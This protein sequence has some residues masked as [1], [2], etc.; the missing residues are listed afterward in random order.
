MG[1]KLNVH[2]AP[3]SGLAR[4]V[5]K[6]VGRGYGRFCSWLPRRIVGIMLIFKLFIKLCFKPYSSLKRLVGEVQ[7]KQ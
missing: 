5:E 7:I 4:D 3:A 6:E 2:E 1:I